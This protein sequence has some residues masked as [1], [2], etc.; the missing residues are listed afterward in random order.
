M[1][2][3]ISQYQVVIPG[4]TITASLWNGMENNIIDNGLV[5][6]GIDDY[7]TNDAQMQ[8]QTDPYPAATT[9]RPTSAQGEL[10]RI[11]FQIA[12]I[13]GETYWY[14]D[15]DATIASLV[16]SVAAVIPSGTK[17]SFYQASVPTGWTAVAVNDKFIRVVTSGTTGGT[18]GG[19]VAASTSLAHTH[20]VDSHTH[21]GPS[22]THTGPS[23]THSIP[24]IDLEHTDD[25]VTTFPGGS[26]IG[27]SRA[28][29]SQ[30]YATGITGA[31]N[32]IWILKN[33]TEAGTTGAGGTGDTGASGTGATGA[34]SPAT[35]SQLG[36]FAYADFCVGT[37]D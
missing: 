17:M 24:Q 36:A 10:E 28:S 21:T 19:T 29:G 27:S 14:Q 5:W 37:K 25:A 33:R 32:N 22:H 18:N 35:D 34:A 8:V 16:T 11:R 30:L 23:H 1:P 20:T 26:E 31:G 13:T 9:S 3:T 7:S 2:G 12:Q 15:P 6:S 4:Q